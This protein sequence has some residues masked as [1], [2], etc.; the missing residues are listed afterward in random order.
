MTTANEMVKKIGTKAFIRD[1]ARGLVYEVD[2]LDAKM[3]YGTVRF[4]VKSAGTMYRSW[5]NEDQLMS[6]AA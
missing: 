3:A 6:A 2:V 4:L 5:V 1:Q